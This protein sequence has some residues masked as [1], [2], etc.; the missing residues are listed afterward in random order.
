MIPISF[1]PHDPDHSGVFS[2]EKPHPLL[3]VIMGKETGM[4]PVAGP[5]SLQGLRIS[6]G[7]LGAPGM[8]DL[9]LLSSPASRESDG[10]CTIDHQEDS[11]SSG[12]STP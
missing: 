12:T 8:S 4:P 5:S 7:C 9:P 11:T 10:F 1:V 2:T 6:L 3:E